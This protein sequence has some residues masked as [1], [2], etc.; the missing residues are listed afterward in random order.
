MYT[1]KELQGEHGVTTVLYPPTISAFVDEKI[2]QIMN[3]LASILFNTQVKSLNHDVPLCTF[4]TGMLA[5]LL[6]ENKNS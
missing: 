2:C 1:G 4:I 5:M 3:N 6:Q